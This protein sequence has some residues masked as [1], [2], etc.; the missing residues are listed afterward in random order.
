MK[1]GVNIVFSPLIFS[2]FQ[3]EPLFFCCYTQEQTAR[4]ARFPLPPPCVCTVP[5]EA[6]SNH[7]TPT[8]CFGS[9]A[10]TSLE[11]EFTQLVLPCPPHHKGLRTQQG[12]EHSCQVAV[13]T[14]GYCSTLRKRQLQAE[15]QILPPLVAVRRLLP[16]RPHSVSV[17]ELN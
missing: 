2:N 9:V 1:S 13:S 5:Q 12:C 14:P 10:S 16:L 7:A 4:S 15:S 17:R 8:H 3:Y 6:V 11:A